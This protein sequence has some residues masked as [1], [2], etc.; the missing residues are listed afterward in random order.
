MGFTTEYVLFLVQA[1]NTTR[2]EEN[3]YQ[4]RLAAVKFNFVMAH[5]SHGP[6]NIGGYLIERLM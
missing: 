5:L 4:H 6:V 1:A 2:I 3:G